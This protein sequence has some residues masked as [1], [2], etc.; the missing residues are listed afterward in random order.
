MKIYCVIL[1]K[2][3]CEVKAMDFFR[4]TMMVI[5]SFVMIASNAITAFFPGIVPKPKSEAE[6]SSVAD[7]FQDIPLAE[8]VIVVRAYRLSQDE[9]ISVH[10]L[11]GLSGRDEAK[12]FIDYGGTSR[13]EL[14]EMEKAGHTLV[15]TDETGA[16][17]NFKSLVTHFSSYIT[18]NSYVLFTDITT[19]EQINMAFNHSTVFGYLAVPESVEAAAK[20]ASLRKAEDLTTDTI[21]IFDQYDFYKKHKKEFRKDSLVHQ[22]GTAHGLRDF[23][24]QQKI[25]ITFTKDDNDTESAFRDILLSDLEPASAILGWCQHEVNFTESLSRFGHF[26]I[27]SDHSMNVSILNCLDLGEIKLG[28]ETEKTELDPDKHYV[29]IVVSDGDNAQ[30]ISNGFGHFYTWQSYD[31]DTPITWTFAPSMDEFSPVAI[32]RAKE[33]VGDD[34]FITGPSGAGY[35]RIAQMSPSEL[36][37][38]SDLTAATMKKSGLTTVTLLDKSLEIP[39]YLFVNKLSY[40]ARYDNIRGGIL[41]IDPTRYEGGKGKVFFVNDKPFVSVRQSLWYPSGNDWEVT[42]E[43]LKEQADIVNSYPADINSISGYSIINV[44]PWTIGADDLAYFVSQL[45][46]GVEVISADELISAISENVPHETAT[47]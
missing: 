6:L 29:A 8:E 33:N 20:E 5:M 41:Q 47:P 4:S 18:D 9:R 34:S 21:T 43:W 37:S 23:A 3:F 46:D 10:S 14:A 22:T 24:V 45:D 25:F 7:I 32:K 17:W 30:W 11:Q 36:A 40:F 12:I 19:T 42:E 39:E 15:Y 26:V 35:A 13:T 16:E 1:L 38:Y 31:I 27:P 44:H 28:K 2:K